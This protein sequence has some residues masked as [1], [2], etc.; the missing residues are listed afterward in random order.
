MSD[1]DRA[2]ITNLAD[3]ADEHAD[4][5]Q[6]AT[7]LPDP[8]PAINTYLVMVKLE[9]SMPSIWRRVE[10]RSDLTLDRV[11]EIVQTVMGWTDSHLH[12][13]QSTPNG[14]AGGV[15]IV[16]P[17]GREESDI[18]VLEADVRLDQILRTVGDTV[19]YLYDFGDSWRHSLTLEAIRAV[20]TSTIPAWCAGGARIAPPEDSGGIH[21][22]ETL[23]DAAKNPSS[24][25]YADHQD[26][27]QTLGLDQFTDEFDPT[28]INEALARVA[29]ARDALNLFTRAPATHQ[30]RRVIQELLQQLTAEGR[31]YV[32]GYL[33]AA[34]INEETRV[35]DDDVTAATRVFQVL[36]DR[37]GENGISLTTAGFLP[38]AVVVELM[39]ELDPNQNWIGENNR[40]SHTRPLLELRN[41]AT[42]LG[43][44]R[45]LKGRLVLTS[46]GT[47]L[48]TDSR[49]LWEHIAARIPVEQT[50][51]DRAAAALGLLLIAAGITEP[52]QFDRELDMLLSIAG[53]DFH[54]GGRYG[55]S[56][57]FTHAHATRHLLRWAGTG[58]LHTRTHR[59]NPLALPRARALATASLTP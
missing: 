58:E 28:P 50:E 34:H 14:P 40:E 49:G 6:P 56:G 31:L 44:L 51:H 35:S 46:R 36:L 5:P 25:E 32:S 19:D 26:Q 41:A 52:R 11:H 38:P 13:F 18:G 3:W 27:I 10:L 43:L 20:D 8:V 39:T 16:T 30:T 23:L 7:V 4:R 59:I 47:A 48:R 29:G 2:R 45:K 22:Y 21:S 12:E 1:R 57:A 15:S 33:S 37:V 55:N 24:S 53:W 17:Y 9:D 42:S 54:S